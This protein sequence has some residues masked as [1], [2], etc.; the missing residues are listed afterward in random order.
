MEIIELR[1]GKSVG[2][3]DTEAESDP[4]GEDREELFMEHRYAVGGNEETR[5]IPLRSDLEEEY[6]RPSLLHTMDI[7]SV[8]CPPTS[9]ITSADQTSARGLPRSQ[10]EGVKS[11][12]FN[13]R[14]IVN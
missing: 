5:E 4:E 11:G 10:M 9:V 13:N 14:F 12:R 2:K 6:V 7:C 8:R 1:S 3:D